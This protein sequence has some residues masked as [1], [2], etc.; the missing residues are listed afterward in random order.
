MVAKS[1]FFINFFIQL[2]DFIGHFYPPVD[3]NR[4]FLNVFDT[5]WMCM[6]IY[7][8][9]E[10]QFLYQNVVLKF[11]FRFNPN[12]CVFFLENNNIS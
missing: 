6:I 2:V 11:I 1:S 7:N 10:D 8:L 5:F 12:D 9:K 3:E 4:N